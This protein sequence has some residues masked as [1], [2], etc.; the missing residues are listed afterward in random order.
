VLGRLQWLAMKAPVTRCEEGRGI[1]DR[2]KACDRVKEGTSVGVAPWH[3][4]RVARWPWRGGAR[5]RGGGA[6]GSGEGGRK[7]RGRGM[8][9]QLGLLGHSGP[10]GWMAVGPFGPN[11]EGKFFFE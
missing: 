1:Y 6:A 11:V 3:R 2:V 4:R 8:V 9:G 5:G 10:K 7:G